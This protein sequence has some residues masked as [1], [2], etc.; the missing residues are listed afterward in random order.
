MPLK[1]QGER[2]GGGKVDA[3]FIGK[4]IICILSFVQVGVCVSL[5]HATRPEKKSKKSDEKSDD[6][7]N[8]LDD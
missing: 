6:R 2:G 3:E 1:R 4:L 7:R 5:W 8:R